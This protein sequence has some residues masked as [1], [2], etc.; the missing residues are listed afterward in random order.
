M[1]KYAGRVSSNISGIRNIVST[2]LFLV[3]T[4]VEMVAKRN[5]RR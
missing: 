5:F 1:T 4:E 2:L 3:Q